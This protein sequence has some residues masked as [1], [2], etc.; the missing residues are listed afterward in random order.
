MHTLFKT[1]LCVILVSGCA[2]TKVETKPVPL[3]PHKPPAKKVDMYV[4]R[5]QA[6]TPD[7]ALMQIGRYTVANA[8]A[9]V[10]QEDLLNVVIKTEI[11]QNEKTVK[12]AMRFLLMRSG[13]SLAPKSM[14][15]KYVEQLLA[16]QLPYAHRNIGP[17]TLK[18]AL[19]MLMGKAFWMKV[20]PVH[21]LIA[22]DTVKEFQ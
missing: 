1:A 9:T 5:Y 3:A 11:P 12:D 22:F 6:E 18:D 20:D 16:K 10:D 17:I 2:Q 4:E 14:Q 8:T 15:G 7:D 13:Y 21:R 19:M